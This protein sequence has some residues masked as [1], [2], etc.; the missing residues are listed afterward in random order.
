MSQ[1]PSQRI[2]IVGGGF[3]GVSL[4]VRLAQSGLPITLLETADLGF[5]ASSRNQGWLHSGGAFARH[6]AGL[7]RMCCDSLRQTVRYCPE[8]IE[9]D[10]VRMF[11][12][13]SRE[14]DAH[15][16]W[17]DAWKAAGIPCSPASREQVAAS[18]PSLDAS[19][20]QH[21]FE[22]PDLAFRPQVLLSRLAN[23]ARQAGVEI[24]TQ[25]PVVGLLQDGDCIRGVRVGT[26]EEIPARATIL[27]TG[28]WDWTSLL[29]PTDDFGQQAKSTRVTLKTHLVSFREAVGAR[30]FCILDR[31][32]FNH[33]PH[34]V[35]SVFGTTRWHP[36][37]GATDHS[38]NP[39]EIELIWKGIGRFFP[40]INRSAVADLREW[41]GLSAQVMHADQII[42]GEAPLPTV[43]DHTREFPRC[44]NLWS[45][46]PGRATLWAHLAEDAAER[47][48]NQFESQ[49]I[50]TT[51]SPW[52]E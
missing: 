37:Q 11:Y 40:S 9:P 35:T 30:P 51:R 28:A 34:G 27:A 10:Q 3:A 4:A 20:V 24:R 45:V 18:L 46:S 2:V 43:I 44:S 13:F 47:I 15:L 23:D 29:T 32:G 26:G 25:T 5:D 38:V 36:A 48:L 42:P 8:C 16:E 49:P 7:A 22:L 21:A 39:Q 1:T 41:S 6:H 19:Q 52:S 50:K 33:V 12:V 14:D 31:D 17:L